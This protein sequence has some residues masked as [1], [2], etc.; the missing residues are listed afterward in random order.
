MSSERSNTTLGYRYVAPLAR[1]AGPVD[2]CPAAYQNIPARYR[3][4]CS[5]HYSCGVDDATG[6]PVEGP[7]DPQHAQR[8]QKNRAIRSGPASSADPNA[9]TRVDAGEETSPAWVGSR[10][11]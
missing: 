3:P 4:P 1:L 6:A 7:V 5:S 8:L 11:A 9:R 2:D 10:E